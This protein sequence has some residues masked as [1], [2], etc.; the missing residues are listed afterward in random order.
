M[1]TFHSHPISSAS[2]HHIIPTH[3]TIYP[4]FQLN[5]NL[6]LSIQENER[7]MSSLQEIP[8]LDTQNNISIANIA[9]FST[10]LVV[11]IVH[12]IRLSAVG[13]LEGPLFRR[14]LLDRIIVFC[15]G[16]SESYP[17]ADKQANRSHAARITG[18]ALYLAASSPTDSILIGALILEGL[19]ATFFMLE[20]VRL[21]VV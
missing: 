20:L 10:P 1:K 6:N 18:S 7:K 13:H 12:I 14:L 17:M 16:Q 9:I 2:Y 8:I 5:S 11:R 15:L 21:L 4:I 3:H 19:G